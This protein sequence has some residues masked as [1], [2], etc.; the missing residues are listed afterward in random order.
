MAKNKYI[1]KNLEN[2]TFIAPV[3][4]LVHP[5]TLREDSARRE[6]LRWT[7]KIFEEQKSLDKL[8]HQIEEFKR[9][10]D[11][12]SEKQK[13]YEM[14]EIERLIKEEEVKKD[15]SFL[16]SLFRKKSA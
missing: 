3:I 9:A 12:M 14:S 10:M 13:E 16:Q 5:S 8:T 11:K 2:I 15:Q 4:S 7:D 6:A 1:A